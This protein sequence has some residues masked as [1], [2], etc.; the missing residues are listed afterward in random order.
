MD[1]IMPVTKS[2]KESGLGM[3]EVL[4]GVAIFSIAILS[5]VKLLK[6]TAGLSSLVTHRMDLSRISQTLENGVDCS[7]IPKTCIAGTLLDLRKTN[8]TV[9]VSASAQSFLS[10]WAVRALCRPQNQFIVQVARLDARGQAV[11]DPISGQN[12]DFNHPKNTLFSEGLLCPARSKSSSPTPTGSISVKTGNICMVVRENE[13]P[14]NPPPPPD[15]DAGQVSI[16]QSID[17][18]GGYA[19]A[20]DLLGLFGQRWLNYCRSL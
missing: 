10:G 14:C 11:K 7:Q 4:V 5:G 3:L 12:L 17:T 8:G 2:D 15:C 16:S 19:N 13:L 18:F 20:G 1:G 9:L 6:N